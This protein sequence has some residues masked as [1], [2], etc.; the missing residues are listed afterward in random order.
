[1]LPP[2]ATAP[3]TVKITAFS[4]VGVAALVAIGANKHPAT[5]VIKQNSDAII[6]QSPFLVF[7]Y[8]LPFSVIDIKQS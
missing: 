1:M 8:T 5:T 7:I 6:L 3:L 4:G 2:P